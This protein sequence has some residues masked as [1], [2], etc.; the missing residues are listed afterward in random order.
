MPEQHGRRDQPLSQVWPDIFFLNIVVWI[1]C[2]YIIEHLFTL[3]YCTV[4]SCSGISNGKIMITQ[5]IHYTNSRN[6][7]FK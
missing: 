5:N 2:S 3:I 1:I 6:G 7:N 4:F